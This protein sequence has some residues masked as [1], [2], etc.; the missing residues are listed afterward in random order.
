MR[1][2]SL[3]SGERGKR[4]EMEKCH[5][6]EFLGSYGCGHCEEVRGEQKRLTHAV[7]VLMPFVHFVATHSPQPVRF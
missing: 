6:S 2:L 1:C 5:Q 7:A 3:P 4:W